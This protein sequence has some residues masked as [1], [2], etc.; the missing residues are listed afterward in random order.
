MAVYTDTQKRQRHD[1]VK[2]AFPLLQTI[3]NQEVWKIHKLTRSSSNNTHKRN[4][5][6]KTWSTIRQSPDIRVNARLINVN[7]VSF[8]C[9]FRCL[10]LGAR[11]R[12]TPFWLK[13]LSLSICL[14]L[15]EFP[16]GSPS[17]GWNV[18]LYVWHKP[19]ELAHSFLF[20]SCVC[21]CLFYGP[22][23]CISFHKFS[24]QLSVC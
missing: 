15:S 24:W 2:A 19:T 5:K 10:Y 4:N 17:R 20:C 1:P 14:C 11:K 12:L 22:F 18:T 9:L 21:F 16:V 8:L 23:S 6:T 7:R 3:C 13:P